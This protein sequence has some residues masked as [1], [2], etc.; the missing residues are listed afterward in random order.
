VIL[1]D[2]VAR[3]ESR[4]KSSNAVRQ[5]KQRPKQRWRNNI[6]LDLIKMV[7][8]V[9]AAWKKRNVFIGISGKILFPQYW[10][11]NVPL[12]AQYFLQM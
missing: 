10:T 1:V 3:T 6:K 5:C 8:N 7:M 11:G 12:P 2:L 9:R 4:R